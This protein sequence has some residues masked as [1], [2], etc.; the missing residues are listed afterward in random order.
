MAFDYRQPFIDYDEENSTF[1]VTVQNAVTD[2]QITSLYNAT[3]GLTLGNQQVSYLIERT[4]KDGAST[5]PPANGEAQREKKWVVTYIG[6]DSNK[7]YTREIP[8]ADWS[9]LTG[10][11]NKLDLAGVEAAAFVTAFEAAA[12]GEESETV[13]VSSIKA[14]GRNI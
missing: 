7:T 1:A 12:A 11:S 2:P 13:T 9:L 14:V 4:D 3:A 5:G 10:N 8:C 6:A